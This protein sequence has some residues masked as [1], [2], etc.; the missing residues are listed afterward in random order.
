MAE[1][2]IIALA[3]LAVPLLIVAIVA[4][5]RPVRV[6]FTGRRHG[7]KAQAVAYKVDRRLEPVQSP[8]P[9]TVDGP[10]ADDVQYCQVCGRSTSPGAKFCRGCGTLLEET[11]PS[12]R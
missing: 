1:L 7:A 10:D 5:R 9:V 12:S 2:A 4:I 11:A 6:D 8:G 3:G